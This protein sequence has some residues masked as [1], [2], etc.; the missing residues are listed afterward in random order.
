M[1]ATSQ[2]VLTFKA[3]IPEFASALDADVAAALDEAD[4][5]LDAKMWNPAD[6][7]WARWWLAAHG[8]KLDQTYASTLGTGGSTSSNS[9]GMFV[10]SIGIGERR[11]MFGERKF[12]TSKN[13]ISGPGQELLEET[14][15]GNKFLRLR[16]R[17]IPAIMV[18]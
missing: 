2:D 15:Y 10:R 17:N 4:M 8:L 7:P 16:S 12:T 6:F 13:G 3:R 14:I 5:W 1:T 9:V 18:V 11:V